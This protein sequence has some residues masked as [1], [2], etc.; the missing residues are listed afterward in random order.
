[1]QDDAKSW[2]I[3]KLPALA[4]EN[5]AMGRDVGQLLWGD[6]QYGYAE[7][8]RGVKDEADRGIGER[9]WYSLYQQSPRPLSG[10]IFKTEKITVVDAVPAGTTLVRAWDLASTAQTGGRNPDWTAG[11]K[12]GKT[13]AGRYIIANMVRVRE[14]PDGV[15][16]TLAAV[17]SQDG[18]GIRISIPQ[19]PGQAGASQVLFITRKLS[20][21][22]VHTSRETGEKATRAMPF[23]SQVN[24]GN[25]GIPR[26]IA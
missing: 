3:I 26:R 15:M 21:Y 12:L 11:A 2:T 1:L 13:P 6:D 18:K 14:G 23:A 25:A 8:I 22:T 16:A 7:L 10:S 19:D 5:D 20:G 4:E 9:D 24:V 17:A